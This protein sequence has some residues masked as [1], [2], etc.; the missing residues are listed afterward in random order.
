MAQ[1][2]A[3]DEDWFELFGARGDGRG[4]DEPRRLAVQLGTARS[5]HVDGSF[6]HLTMYHES[7]CAFEATAQST[8]NLRHTHT[9]TPERHCTVSQRDERE[10]H[11]PCGKKGQSKE[12]MW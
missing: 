11:R 8:S 10:R 5:R 1:D 6:W 3:F 2:G 9:H 7:S 12:A 4:L